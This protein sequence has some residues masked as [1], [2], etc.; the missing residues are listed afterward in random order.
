MKKILLSL[1]LLLASTATTMAYTVS[2]EITYQSPYVSGNTHDTFELMLKIRNT[3]NLVWDTWDTWTDRRTGQRIILLKEG[4]NTSVRQKIY[5]NEVGIFILKFAATY[6]GEHEVSMQ[7]Y[8]PQKNITII[9]TDKLGNTYVFWKVKV[10]SYSYIEEAFANRTPYVKDEAIERLDLIDQQLQKEDESL[11]FDFDISRELQ[12]SFDE[13][14]KKQQAEY[15]E[16][17]QA[18]YLERQ[19]AEYLERQIDVYPDDYGPGEYSDSAQF[20]RDKQAD[21]DWR[22]A[23]Y[24][25]RQRIEYEIE[26]QLEKELDDMVDDYWEK[27]INSH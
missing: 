8:S 6:S 25:E 26:R 13:Y 15:L 22:E 7:P 16:R 3:S 9:P 2:G 23:K 12:N 21:L 19:Q 17:Q 27:R 24:L 14:S 20:E 10:S 18:E 4:A 11:W 5:K 1:L